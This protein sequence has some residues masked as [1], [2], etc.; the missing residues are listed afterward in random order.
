MPEF[1]KSNKKNKTLIL[2]FHLHLVFRILLNMKHNR[3]FYSIKGDLSVINSRGSQ[4]KKNLLG[5]VCNPRFFVAMVIK[6]PIGSAS[7]KKSQ[8]DIP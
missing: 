8:K 2:L 6:P 7:T 3:Q 4:T 1:S 5:K